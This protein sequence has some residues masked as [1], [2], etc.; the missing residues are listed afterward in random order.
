MAIYHNS[1]QTNSGRELENRARNGE[2]TIEFTHIRTGSGT[3][4]EDEK[5]TLNNAIDLKEARQEF[6]FTGITLKKENDYLSLESVIAN[7]GLREGYYLSE[8]GIYAR[9][10]G[11]MEEILYCIGLVDYPDYIPSDA[12]E[13]YEIILQSLIKCYDAANVVIQYEENTYATAEALH[14]HITDKDNPHDIKKKIDGVYQQA[15]GYTDQAIADLINGAPSTLDTLGEIAQAMQD[16][17]D[18]VDAL[19]QAIGTK[20]SQEEINLI[21]YQ[22]TNIVPTNVQA[23]VDA[24]KDD[25]RGATGLQGAKGDK[26]DKG[27][28][29]ATGPQ[30][31][32]GDTGAT[33]PQGPSGSPWGG[34]TFTGNVH[35]NYGLGYFI[36][37]AC[38]YTS[39]NQHLWISSSREEPYQ[40]FLGVHGGMW[41]FCPNT[42]NNSGDGAIALGN[43]W[44]RWG[45]IYS[46][47][48]A[49]STS[50]RNRKK[51][52]APMSD[53]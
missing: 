48:S 39:N 25:L 36:G 24:H 7:E 38:I 2:G 32:K 42:T 5:L 13:R 23:Y 11:T 3:Y 51:D 20:A 35:L 18:V 41:S 6:L 50:D 12:H 19:D 29:G 31:P 45:T 40:I 15:T 8:L 33:G 10:K 14:R 49:I 37:D 53:K 17:E 26:G 22:L 27:D 1:K 46:T 44:V 21:N 43:P 16:N 28:T 30:G 9:L 52:I 47:G 4:T 34:G